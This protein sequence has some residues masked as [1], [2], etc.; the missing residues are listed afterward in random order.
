MKI[1]T[2]VNNA[3][4]LSPLFLMFILYATMQRKNA[5]IFTKKNRNKNCRYETHTQRGRKKRTSK[6]S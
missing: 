4:A 3:F 5:F 6:D 1:C 2:F